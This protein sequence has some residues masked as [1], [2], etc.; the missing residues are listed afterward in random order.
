MLAAV[1]FVTASRPASTSTSSALLGSSST[2]QQQRH[3][4]RNPSVGTGHAYVSFGIITDVHYADAA[5]SGTR[6]YR[7]SLPKVQEAVAAMN[8]ADEPV[9]FMIELGDFKDTDVS[10]HCDK[11]PSPSCVNLTVGFLRQIEGA[12][13]A[14]PGPKFH[15]LGNHD[16]DILNQSIVLANEHNAPVDTPDSDGFYSFAWPRPRSGGLGG[17]DTS[18]CLA[19]TNG[20]SNVWI[21]HKDGSRNWLS[22][23]T[24][25]CH[26]QAHVVPNINVYP[27]RHGAQSPL[28]PLNAQDSAVACRDNPPC[29]VIPPAPPPAP[30]PPLRFIVL[31]GDFTDEDVPWKDLDLPFPGEAWDKA[32][33]PSL[34]MEWL[35]QQLD[36]AARVGQKVIIFVHYRL[37]GGP[38]GPVCTG[39]GA[40]CPKH[41]LAAHAR[42]T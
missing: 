18:G 29:P 10:K 39:L 4:Q 21:V 8:R 19:A 23:P 5:P 34:Q 22:K 30:T 12:L 17:N 33:V 7:D 3:H 32:N 16:V 1:W 2:M 37:D 25:G 20:T 36:D 11:Q 31:N 35:A 28:Y 15:V 40:T 9:D 42:R 24:A 6:I 41:A 27:K 38:G 14:Y 13:S 26:Q